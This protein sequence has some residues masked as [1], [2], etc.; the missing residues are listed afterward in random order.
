MSA[1]I[2]RGNVTFTFTVEP[3]VILALLVTILL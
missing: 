1:I 3:S 2:K